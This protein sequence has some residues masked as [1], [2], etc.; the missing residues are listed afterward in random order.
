MTM[1]LQVMA[2][3]ITSLA[4]LTEERKLPHKMLQ[5]QKLTMRV[6][7]AVKENKIFQVRDIR[8]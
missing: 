6:L 7:F 1:S 5:G 3:N 4:L 2:K 8:F